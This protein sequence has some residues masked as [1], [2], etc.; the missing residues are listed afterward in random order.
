MAV[1]LI[2]VRLVDGVESAQAGDLS[3]GIKK[4]DKSRGVHVVV[5][6]G[7]SYLVGEIVEN[8][9]RPLECQAQTA[10]VSQ[11]VRKRGTG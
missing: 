2:N 10:I 5:W 8:Y 9:A 3:L 11:S 6:G 1:K 7:N 4:S